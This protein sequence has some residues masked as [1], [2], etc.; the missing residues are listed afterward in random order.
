M[1]NFL[2]SETNGYSLPLRILGEPK[3]SAWEFYLQQPSK[4]DSPPS[5][6][7]DLSGDVGGE[8]AGRKFYLSSSSAKNTHFSTNEADVIKSDQ[9][10]LARF[11]CD[12]GSTFKFMI[13]FAGLRVW[14]L[15]ALLAVL[16]P[17]RLDS[18]T[19][20]KAED[21]AHKLG[22]GRPLGMGSV[23]VTVD[24]VRA[25][26]GRDIDLVDLSGEDGQLGG[27]TP[28]SAVAALKTKAKLDSTVLDQWLAVHRYVDRGRLDYPREMTKV[29]GQPKETIYA[30]HTN[31]HRRFSKLRRQADAEWSG[32]LQHI[33]KARSGSGK[34]N[35]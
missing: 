20:A 23:R 4:S 25:R 28:E 9:A 11:I 15:G 26:R 33:A 29:D 24:A 30:W 2:G 14:E 32:L 31:L 22:L 19:A 34:G 16:E 3:P 35:E 12:R 13:R 18:S 6:Y 8:L 21:F 1:P 7:G 10:T 5:T 27:L 17:H